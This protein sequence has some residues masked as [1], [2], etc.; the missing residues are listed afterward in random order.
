[1]SL[2][3]CV[4]AKGDLDTTC[5]ESRVSARGNAL[6]QLDRYG[7]T[8]FGPHEERVAVASF[9]TPED[10]FALKRRLSQ[11]AT[12]FHADDVP[13]LE[14]ANAQLLLQPLVKQVP[15]MIV[16]VATADAA[17]IEW[18]LQDIHF[19]LRFAKLRWGRGQVVTSKILQVLS[20][21]GSEYT[22]I[23]PY[24][25]LVID[26]RFTDSCRA[27]GKLTVLLLD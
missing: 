3:A 14:E 27:N 10:A 18:I 21:I 16:H 22:G 9:I 26:A 19:T 12:V 20:M 5:S 24:T 17:V 8:V 15:S 11:N 6:M 4:Y 7:R 23:M 2:G 13:A 25:R 1:M